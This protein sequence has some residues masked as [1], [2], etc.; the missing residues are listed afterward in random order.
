MTAGALDTAP[1][2]SPARSAG[3]G[4]RPAGAL[5]RLLRSLAFRIGATVVAVEVVVLAFIGGYAVQRL[6]DE[7]D[8][9]LRDRITVPGELM[10]SGVLAYDAVADRAILTD[11]IGQELEEGMVVGANWNVFHALDPGQLGRDIRQLHALDPEWF[12]PAARGPTLAEVTEDGHTSL[13]A[14]TPLYVRG[15]DVPTLFAYIR[16]NTT[17][18]T[19]QKAAVAAHVALASLLCVVLTSA[20]LFLAFKVTVLR[21]IGRLVGFVRRI[22]AG[23]KDVPALDVG[24]DELGHLE[25]GVN[26]MAGDLDQ[27]ARQRD[28]MEA[29]LRRSESRFRDFAAAASDWYWEL[30]EALRYVA[31]SDRFV[32]LVRPVVSPL[33]R[34]ADELGV[35][36]AEEGGWAPFME[37]L[38]QRRPVHE[39]DVTWRDAEGAERFARLA[40]LPVFDAGG[41]FAGYR[42]TGRDITLHRRARAI[43]E[44]QVEER[45]RAL[46]RA[47]RDL[48]ETLESLNRAQ[49]ELVRSEKLASLGALVAGVAHEINTPVGVAVTAASH[50]ADRTHATAEMLRDGKLKRADLVGYFDM[51]DEA[52]RLLL[53]N[54]ERASAL[55]QSFKLVATDRTAEVL[56]P[57][58]LKRYLEDIVVSLSPTLRKT[59]H[60]IEVDCPDGVEMVGY[61]GLLSQVVTNLVMNSIV[62]AY[63]EGVSGLLRITV[64][65]PEPEVVEVVYGDD[66]RGIAPDH[67]SKIFDPF[68]TTR[69]GAGSSGLG[70]NIVHNIVTG[71]LHGKVTVASG[72]GRGVTFTLRL[73]RVLEEQAAAAGAAEPEPE[74]S[75]GAPGTAAMA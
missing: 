56:R 27:R 47:N 1:A 19:E 24:V 21:R 39:F 59:P 58:A 62:H 61:P 29:E 38:R 54:M 74:P 8:R 48:Q 44:Q 9:R 65:V 20:M 34:R 42:G 40:G 36:A 72:P 10:A 75:A 14:V 51:A 18:V 45:T 4:G 12:S 64:R 16:V 43:L 31:V 37:R 13:V 2:A 11:L 3:A 71:S 66:G 25:S 67:L 46:K 6:S 23:E 26:A 22:G 17:G 63:D 41:G 60:R 28:R 69:R 53:H 50:L 7:V 68:F 73:P 5:R 33:G 70:L 35:D 52:A 15:A 30:D 55:I 57:F 49:A 32:E